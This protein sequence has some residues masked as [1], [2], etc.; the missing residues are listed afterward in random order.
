MDD[1]KPPLIKPGEYPLGFEY[2]ETARLFNQP[3]L[4]LWFTVLSDDEYHGVKLKRFYNVRSLKGKPGKNGEYHPSGWSSDL[5][6]EYA[7][8]FGEV[9]D[10]L[11][12]FT[13]KPYKDVII[14]GDVKTV[15]L[16]SRKRGIPSCV[17]YSVIER[18]IKA[19]EI[20]YT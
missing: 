8:L 9:P 20:T 16:D 18:L 19:E 7:E 17:Q 13:L 2:H 6:R 1:Q 11:D 12:R 4:I 3:K 10:R 5:V 14:I 15:S